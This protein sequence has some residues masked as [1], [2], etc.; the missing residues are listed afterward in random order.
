MPQ[1]ESLRAPVL[2]IAALATG[3]QAGTYYTWAT[4]VMPGLA[5]VDDR[6]FVHA[7]Q[8]MNIAIVN[9]AFLLTFLGA[10]LLTVV[11]AA[12]AAPQAR[13]WAWGAAV[14]AIATI[15]ITMGGNIPLNNALDR[16][17]QVDSIRDLHAVRVAFE[18]P[19]ARLNVLRFLTSAL[20]LGAAVVAALRS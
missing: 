9:P 14:L 4:G 16:A 18:A 1:L 5:R 19:W 10:P 7:M 17:G 6:T 8:Q 15:V 11:A 20:S 12:I 2:V 13:P 3:L